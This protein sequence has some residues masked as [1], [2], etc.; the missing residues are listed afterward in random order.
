ML[1]GRKPAR[2]G[3]QR[4]LDIWFREG[5]REPGVDTVEVQDGSGV[6]MN[7]KNIN[8]STLL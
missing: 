7:Q 5:C 2:R 1:S 3:D 4:T 8:I 6:L